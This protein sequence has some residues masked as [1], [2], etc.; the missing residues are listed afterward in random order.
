V[1]LARDRVCQVCRAASS[2]TAHHKVPRHISH[3]DSPANL[4]ALC[5]ACHSE[6]EQLDQLD[7]YLDWARYRT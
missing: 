2:L 3:D 5:R 7:S 1:V 4:I 6:V